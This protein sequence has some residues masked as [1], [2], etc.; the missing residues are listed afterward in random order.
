MWQQIMRM[1]ASRHIW[2]AN[3][4]PTSRCRQLP[5]H[6]THVALVSFPGNAVQVH[7]LMD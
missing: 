1:R 5:D 4:T 2:V 3:L 6:H 7:S